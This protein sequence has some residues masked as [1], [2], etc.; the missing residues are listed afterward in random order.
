[1]YKNSTPA[2][3]IQQFEV[4]G[5]TVKVS[6]KGSVNI[7]GCNLSPTAVELLVTARASIDAVLQEAHKVSAERRKTQESRQ[8]QAKLAREAQKYA[9]MGDAYLNALIEEAKR[10]KES[11]GK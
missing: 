8:F 9:S 6:D 2:N 11:Q 3:W 10:L 4:N 7:G 1:M 5:I